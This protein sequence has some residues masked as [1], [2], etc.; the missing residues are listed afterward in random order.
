M[1]LQRNSKSQFSTRKGQIT[2]KACKNKK[3][4]TLFPVDDLNWSRCFDCRQICKKCGGDRREGTAC[5][6]PDPKQVGYHKACRAIRLRR[7]LKN[8]PI[9]ESVENVCS[10]NRNSCPSAPS[11]PLATMVRRLHCEM[12]EQNKKYITIADVLNQSE[13]EAA[14]AWMEDCKSEKI[15]IGITEGDQR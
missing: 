8:V 5:C 7:A 2:C 11:I 6:N 3:A 15:Q 4:K 13:C 1:V 12:H 9:S 14:L 10:S